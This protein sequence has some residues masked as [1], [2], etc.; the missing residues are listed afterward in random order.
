MFISITK[1]LQFL[2]LLSIGFSSIIAVSAQE[3]P[4]LV[5]DRPDQTESATIVPPGSLQVETGL[6]FSSD[7]RGLDQG[8]DKEQTLALGTTLVS[9]GLL[10]N[11]ELRLIGQH[12]QSQTFL[13]NLKDSSI[14]NSGVSDIAIGGKFGVT[15]EDGMIPEIAL[16]L[17]MG[18]PIGGDNFRPNVAVPDFRL[19][20]AKTLTEDLSLGL[21]LGAEYSGDKPDGTFVYTLSLAMGLTDKLGAYIETYGDMPS[22]EKLNVLVD[23]GFTYLVA[24]L[25]QLDLE[26]GY[27]LSERTSLDYFIAGGISFRLFK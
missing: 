4:E 10:K 12:S 16:N 3:T 19:L 9:I 2:V 7:S 13:K 18:L 6:T 25:V 5:T 24:P 27:S 22:T 1:Y 20:L 23:G 15:E 8:K 14:K 26:A 17:H 21:N 11:L